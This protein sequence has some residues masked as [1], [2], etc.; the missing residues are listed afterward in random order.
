MHNERPDPDYYDLPD[1][2]AERLNREMRKATGNSYSVSNSN[3][4]ATSVFWWVVALIV[5]IVIFGS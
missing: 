3:F 2:W 5:L 1:D 4:T